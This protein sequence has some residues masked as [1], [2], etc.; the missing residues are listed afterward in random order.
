MI[1]AAGAWTQ[2]ALAPVGEEIE[3]RSVTLP[4][5]TEVSAL[6]QG[7]WRMGEDASRRKQEIA[8]L[9]TGI[10]LGMT[11]VDTAEMYGDGATE[12]LLGEALAGLRE[13]VFLVSK[14]YPHNASRR[15]VRARSGIG[16]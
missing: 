13:K 4:D 1:D 14:V 16:A 7:T 11:V 10:D 3:M 15:G 6:G 5:H 2:L 9:R 12:T 8:A